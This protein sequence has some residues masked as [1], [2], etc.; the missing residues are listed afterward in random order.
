MN[1]V[2]IIWSMVASACLTLAAMHLLV[3][4]KKRAVWANLVFSL[5]AEA[6]AA[7]AFCELWMM[8]AET[9][10]GSAPSSTGAAP[11]SAPGGPA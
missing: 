2:I 5:M 9:P 8:Q 6:T 3:W 4:F 1:W 7:L 10:G 11:R